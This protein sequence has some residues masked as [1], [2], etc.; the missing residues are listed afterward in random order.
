MDLQGVR[1]RVEKEIDDYRYAYVPGLVG[2]PLSEEK[3]QAHLAALRAALV[4]PYL[5]K[6]ARRDTFP[7]IGRSNPEI[8]ECVIVADDGQGTLLAYDPS[9]CEFLLVAKSGPM[10]ASF[11]ITGDAVGCF[12]AR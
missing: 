7:A 9:T 4:E 5:A 10:L 1:R 6:V 3:V 2:K 8:S 12:M 11:G